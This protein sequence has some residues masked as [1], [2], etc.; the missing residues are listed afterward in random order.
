[1]TCAGPS[2]VCIIPRKPAHLRAGC[3]LI[4]HRGRWCATKNGVKPVTAPPNISPLDQRARP[5]GRIRH[6]PHDVAS[7]DP[8]E[9][10]VSSWDVPQLD[11]A[12]I[13]EDLF[14]KLVAP[15]LPLRHSLSLAGAR[16]L[17]RQL[18]EATVVRREAAMARV[19]WNRACAFDLT[20]LVRCRPKC[21]GRV[22]TSRRRWSDSGRTGAVPRH[23]A[24]PQSDPHRKLRSL[25]AGTAGLRCSY[26]SAD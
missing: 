9:V 19:G 23:C 3:R 6:G 8:P 4:C 2:T 10:P 13:D 14:H 5:A 20:S 17:A 24:M 25:A 15:P 12:Q 11:L 22:L 1:M 26:W 21:C 7:D 18:Y 16:V